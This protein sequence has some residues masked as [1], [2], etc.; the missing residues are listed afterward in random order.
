MAKVESAAPI[1]DFE[2][3][4]QPI[5][6]EY[7][8]GESQQYS[9]VYDEIRE[10]R[11][12]DDTLSQGEWQTELKIADFRQVI[13]LAVP[14]LETQTKDLQIAAWLSEALI[15]EHGFVGLRDGLRM[16]NGLQEKFWE[17]M[18]PEID[19]GDMEGRANALEWTDTQAA[20]AIKEAKLTDGAGYGYFGFEDSKKFDI[21]ENIDTLDSTDQQKYREL[22]AQAEKENRPTAD[23]WR[24]AKAVTRR[25]FYEQLS[26]DLEECFAEHKELNRIIEEKFDRNQMPGTSQLK[27]SLDDIQTLVKRLLEDKRAEEPDS[28]DETTADAEPAGD[29]ADGAAIVGKI[30]TVAAGAIQNRKD[31]L[32]RLS[33]LADFFLKTEPHSPLSYL[34]GRAVKWGEMPLESWLQDVIKD[35]AVLFQLRQT[36]GF[37][38]NAGGGGGGNSGDGSAS[39]VEDDS[40]MVVY[41]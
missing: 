40:G 2:A 11:R 8:A 41:E 37:N 19:E 30:V 23:K 29:G 32:K 12:A 22:Q 17:T 9:G 18:F 13:R 27:K 21:P 14:V 1:L 15:K 26:F 16:L 39:R 4:T 3:I 25:A 5:S 33:D 28:A 20:F 34:I 36:L 31:A 24:K 7:P 38:T 35:E 10:S 6:E